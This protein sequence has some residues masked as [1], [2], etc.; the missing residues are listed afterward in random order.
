MFAPFFYYN[1]DL[2]QKYQYEDEEDFSIV[3]KAFLG[4]QIPCKFLYSRIKLNM[5]L[6]YSLT[7]L[8][9]PVYR[10]IIV[11]TLLIK[12]ISEKLDERINDLAAD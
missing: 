4:I 6:I 8:F 3:C 7:F 5:S 2:D 10:L 9:F 11:S 1:L 12:S